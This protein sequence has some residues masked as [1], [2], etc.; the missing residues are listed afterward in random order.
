MRPANTTKAR[1]RF[2]RELAKKYPTQSD[3]RYWKYHDIWSPPNN[4][5]GDKGQMFT[6][7]K[8]QIGDYLGDYDK[9]TRIDNTGWY[10]DHHC[11]EVVKCG[12]AKLRCPKGTLYIPVTYCTGWDGT[13]HYLGDA[14]LVP[15]K[16]TECDHE[17]AIK[18][19]ARSANH[20][21]EKTAEEEREYQA[22]DRAEQDI[23]E[24]QC[25]IH[26][27]N[28]KCLALIKSIKAHGTFDG[29]VCV[30]LQEKVQDYLAE[31][32]AAFNL[33]EKRTDDFW[34]AVGY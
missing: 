17:R 19:A 31:R 3:W 16:G 27:I 32:R 18:E 6:E 4:S 26:T 1:L 10:T 25:E 22:K 20:Y 30:A 12:V 8:D 7:S 34:S 15:K 14:E 28:Q 33:I 13:V 5:I 9:L 29:P 24:A 2:Y 21:A 11:S 23:Y